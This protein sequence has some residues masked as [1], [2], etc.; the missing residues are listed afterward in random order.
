M[1]LAC[2][3][4][5]SKK[6]CLWRLF[7]YHLKAHTISNKLVSN[8]GNSHISTGMANKTSN[9]VCVFPKITAMIY[10]MCESDSRGVCS[11]HPV[12]E[13]NML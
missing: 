5:S 12:V 3:D 13:N 4:I 10:N 9:L 2:L 6:R 1:T 8:V 7:T 11:V